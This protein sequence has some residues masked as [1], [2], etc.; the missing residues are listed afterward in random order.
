MFGI[1]SDERQIYFRSG[2][3]SDEQ[4]GKVWCPLDLPHKSCELTVQHSDSVASSLCSSL[5]MDQLGTEVRNHAQG[6]ANNI[7]KSISLQDLYLNETNNV[8][9]NIDAES[10]KGKGMFDFKSGFAVSYKPSS[11]VVSM[12][13]DDEEKS[14][15]DELEQPGQRPSNDVLETCNSLSEA[16]DSITEHNP[17]DLMREDGPDILWTSISAS[18]CTISDE[19]QIRNW[20]VRGGKGITL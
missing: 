16:L 12:S 20:L 18:A 10:K 17:S 8:E 7:S 19:S 13:A 9:A 15:T 1:D 6:D 3:T 2:I 4:T 11:N 14:E 5:S